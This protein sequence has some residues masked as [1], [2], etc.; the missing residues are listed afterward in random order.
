[1]SNYIESAGSD[2]EEDYGLNPGRKRQRQ[3]KPTVCFYYNIV[4]LNAEQV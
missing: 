3:Q 2:E 1:M 4:N